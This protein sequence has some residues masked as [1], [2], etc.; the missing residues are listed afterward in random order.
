M[1]DLLKFH[2]S[3][4]YNLTD[5]EFYLL[6]FLIILPAK[7]F[8]LVDM[9]FKC[10]QHS[11]NF[12]INYWLS[13]RLVLSVFVQSCPLGVVKCFLWQGF[14]ACLWVSFAL[15]TF[16]LCWKIIEVS[17]LIHVIDCRFNNVIIHIIG[18]IVCLCNCWCAP[19]N[20][21]SKCIST[22]FTTS[23]GRVPEQVLWGRWLQILPIFICL[24]QWGW[25]MI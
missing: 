2:G 22:C 17:R 12:L 4:R 14:T 16:L 13:D 15:S 7:H 8:L 10:I 21:N 20:G 25:R 5:Y 24:T 18:I 9:F 3:D 23:L 1:H 19:R 6:L 11:Y